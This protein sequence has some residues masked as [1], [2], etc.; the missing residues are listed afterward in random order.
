VVVAEYNNITPSRVHDRGGDLPGY[1]VPFAAGTHN[2]AQLGYGR[3]RRIIAFADA[4]FSNIKYAVKS[5]G[6]NLVIPASFTWP[7]GIPFDCAGI[8]EITT[9][10]AIFVFFD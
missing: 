8:L 2:F 4:E 7:A 10:A 5:K 3:A 6:V 1:G 9:G